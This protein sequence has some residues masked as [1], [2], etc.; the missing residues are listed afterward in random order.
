[1]LLWYFDVYRS[2]ASCLRSY[3]CC[4]EGHHAPVSLRRVRPASKAIRCIYVT[5]CLSS[6][7]HRACT[8]TVA[9]SSSLSGVQYCQNLQWP[10][11][12][13]GLPFDVS[14][15]LPAFSACIYGVCISSEFVITITLSR[16]NS[17]IFNLEYTHRI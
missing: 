5:L 16:A 2:F 8:T 13:S 4:Y 15:Q 12:P 11:E 3:S 14:I 17:S 10:L 6:M 1:M 7:Q 9:H